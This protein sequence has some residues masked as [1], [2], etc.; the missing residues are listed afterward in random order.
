MILAD[1]SIGGTNRRILVHFDR[2]GFGY[3]L[4]RVNGELLVAEKYGPTVNRATMVDMDKNSK[5][6]G[7]PLV[8]SKYSTSTPS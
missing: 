8:V 5:T 4:D 2:N 3:T 1:Q 7:R 6:Y